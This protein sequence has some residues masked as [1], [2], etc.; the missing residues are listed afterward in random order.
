MNPIT[1][2]AERSLFMF[3]KSIRLPLI[4]FVVR[5][6]YQFIKNEEI[7]WIENISISFGIFLFV[8]LFHWADK[9]YK[10][11]KDNVQGKGK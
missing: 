2:R 1:W 11:K 8:L 6:L 9:P 7:R 4:Y 5:V 10:W 3:K